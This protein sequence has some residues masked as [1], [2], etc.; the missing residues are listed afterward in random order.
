MNRLR[1]LL[2]A[3]ALA[4]LTGCETMR[5]WFEKKGAKNDE[6]LPK[7]T[8][9]QFVTYLNERAARLQSINYGDVRLVARDRNL[10][11]PIAL[12]GSLAASQPRNFRMTG[13]GGAVATKVDLGSNSDQFWVYFAAPTMNPMFVYASHNDF[14][15]GKAKIPGGIPFDPDWVMQALGMTVLPTNNQYTVNIDQKARTYTLSWPA[16]TPANVSVVKEIVF[17]GDPATGTRPQV[18]KHLIRDTKGNVIC[19]AEVKTARTV[20]LSTTDPNSGLPLSIQHPTLMVL[21]WEQQ[22]FEMELELKTGEVNRPMADEQARRLFT[23]PNIPGATPLDLAKY[24]FSGG[25]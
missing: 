18:K 25:K 24:E 5:S 4:P 17:D 19:S 13:Q 11:V 16:V 8:P 23:R 3:A 1:L 12:H 9:D 7:K 2:V 22:K 20:Q 6:P 15:D 10:P 14:N 21:K